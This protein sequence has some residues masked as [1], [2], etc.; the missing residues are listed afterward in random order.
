MTDRFTN[1]PERVYTGSM[2]KLMGTDLFDT[3]HPMTYF[4]VIQNVIWGLLVIISLLVA[5]DKGFVN[6]IS[7]WPIPTAYVWSVAVIL[8][9]L[10]Q[11]WFLLRDHLDRSRKRI[12]T[13][14][15]VNLAIWSFSPIL[16][17]AIGAYSML[18]V[19]VFGIVG[20]SYIGLANRLGRLSH[21]V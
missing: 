12:W 11:V 14:A 6:S 20:F 9:A 19:S 7:M 3:I 1:T 16:W 13:M 10:V 21:R 18:V 5:G 2:R 8:A 17:I 15:K 4:F